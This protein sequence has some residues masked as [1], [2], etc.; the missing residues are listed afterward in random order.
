[1][2]SGG[3]RSMPPAETVARHRKHVSPLTGVVSHLERIKSE[4]PLDASFL[5]KHNF[6][7]RPETVE[8][9]QSGL[10]GDSYGKGSTAE[11]GE[12]SAL[13]E[14]IERYCGI[15]QGD[16]IRTIRRFVDFPAGDAILP[17]DVLLLSD[18]QFEHDMDDAS[19]SE[20]GHAA[21]LRSVGRDRMVAGV[22]AARRALQV[23][24]DRP[25][26]F[27]S[28]GSRHQPDQ[29]RLQRLRGRQHA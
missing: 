1:M 29:C 14:A 17:N 2:T 23:P 22:V 13:M 4:Q 3:Y 11:Q 7:P 15:F 25:P 9:L 5:A 27:L 24:S 19:C 26:V 18:A 12:A 20:R 8:A 21:P 16:E 28:P 10:I 6:S